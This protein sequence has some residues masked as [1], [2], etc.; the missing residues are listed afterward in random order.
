MNKTLFVIGLLIVILA[1]VFLLLGIVPS[2]LAIAAAILGI[3]L[4]FLSRR[5]ERPKQKSATEAQ[6]V[7]TIHSAD[8][9][10]RAVIKQRPDGKYQVEIQ[11]FVREYSQEFGQNDRWVR[12]SAPLTDSLP[13][14]VE[15]ATSHVRISEEGS[16]TLG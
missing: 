8:G 6:V 9:Q 12:Q 4:I 7:Q 14:A 13:S 11:R 3:G 16:G 10:M 5:G 1:A 2:G 15:I